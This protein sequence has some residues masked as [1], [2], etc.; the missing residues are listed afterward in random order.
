MKAIRAMIQSP[1][2]TAQEKF[3]A[4]VLIAHGYG[5]WAK[6]TGLNPTAYAI[7]EHQWGA[8]SELLQSVPNGDVARVN[9]ALEWMNIGPSAYQP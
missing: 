2:A 4:V 5:L 7:P 6:E 1:D 8:I 3:E 9:M